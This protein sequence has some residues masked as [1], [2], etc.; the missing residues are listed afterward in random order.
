MNKIDRK[1]LTQGT[2]WKRILSFSVPLL[3]GNLAQQLYNTVDSM[4]VGKYVGDNA[5]AAVGASGPLLNFLILFFVGISTGVNIMVSQYFGGKRREELGKSIGTA[6]MLTG[7]TSIFLIAISPFVIHP[8]L[9]LINTPPEILDWAQ[10][11]LKILMYGIAGMAYFNILSGILRG[12]GDSLSG[13]YYLLISTILNIILDL[14]FVIV[15]DMGVAGVS[16]ATVIAQGVSALLAFN[17]LMKYKD[18][19]ELKK[20]SFSLR[21]NYASQML[22]L[23]LPSGATQGIFSLAMLL[24]QSLSNQFGSQFIAA[25]L[26]VMRVDGLAMLP[27]FSFGF[28]MTTY[29]GQN[30]GANR[31]D[32]VI[33]GTKQGTAL[34]LTSSIILTAIILIFGHQL[35]MLFTQTSELA[36]YALRL[37]YIIAPGY[38]C[39]SITQ[40]LGGVMRGAG[41]TMTPM[42]ISVFLTLGIRVP[43][44]YG[45]SYLT[46]SPAYPIG[47]PESVFVSLL[48]TWVFGAILTYY[49]YRRGGWK[50]K[51]LQ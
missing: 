25:N 17:K 33:E 42:W 11:Y 35:M 9:R 46:R 49:F 41:D 2:P 27:N 51:A 5:L 16:L 1:D 26:M 24:V 22:R 37:M 3:L 38:I 40:S 12:L 28:A 39:F 13:L 45:L 23:G 8:F 15:Y 18:I 36:D 48:F 21:G 47:R 50:N 10:S 29:T 14:V 30:I 32:R 7:I 20:S 19:F 44:A 31:L 43:L 4:V 6:V 34:A